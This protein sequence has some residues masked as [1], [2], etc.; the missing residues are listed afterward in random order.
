VY[1]KTK[2]VIVLGV[3]RTGT[4]GLV[5][6]LYENFEAACPYHQLHYGAHEA[7]PIYN[8]SYWGDFSDEQ[9]WQQFKSNYVTCDYFVLSGIDT[10]EFDQLRGVDFFDFIFNLLDKMADRENVTS[11][12]MKVEPEMLWRKEGRSFLKKLY[13]RYGSVSFIMTQRDFSGYLNSYINMP[14]ASRR[15]RQNKIGYVL[16]LILGGARYG[17]YSRRR[18]G[19]ISQG[20]DAIKVGFNSLVEDRVRLLSEIRSSINLKSR[21]RILDSAIRNSSHADTKRLLGKWSIIFSKVFTFPMV[22]GLVLWFYEKMRMINRPVS[23]RLKLNDENPAELKRQLRAS[24]DLAL[25]D[26]L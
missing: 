21:D 16:S 1:Q 12:L 8:Q 7:K 2:P 3:A 20:H 14:G 4:T 19:I 9:Q 24:G 25:L 15:K 10:D 5:N 6:A 13:H 23:Y 26:L 11:W 22:S 18:N 17:E